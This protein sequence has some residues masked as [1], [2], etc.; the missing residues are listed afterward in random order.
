M[1]YNIITSALD[2]VC[3]FALLPRFGIG[4]YFISFTVTHAL[5]FYLSI[6]CLFRTVGYVPGPRFFLKGFACTAAATAFCTAALRPAASV[7]S[8]LTGGTV[9]LGVGLLLFMLSGVF[10]IRELLWLRQLIV[11]QPRAPE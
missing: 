5:N 11:G 4:G 9:Y 6:T 7:A 2:I 1:R 3:L 10:N 8:I